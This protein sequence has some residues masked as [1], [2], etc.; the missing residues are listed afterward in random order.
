MNRVL[1]GVVVS[2]VVVVALAGAPAAGGAG[3]AL[4][5]LLKWGEPGTAAGLFDRPVFVAVDDVGNVFVTDSGNHRVQ[6]FNGDGEFLGGWGGLGPGD[7]QFNLPRGIAFFDGNEADPANYIY[8]VD[9]LNNRVQKFT[10]SGAF[11]TKWGSLGPGDGQFLVPSGV[12]VGPSGNVYVVDT[13]HHRV[14][15]FS[16]TGAFLGT[17]GG[18]GKAD[19]QFLNAHG[20]AVDE[21]E[22]VYVADSGYPSRVQVF[23]AG[24]AHLDTWTSFGTGTASAF[25][26]P[27]VAVGPSGDVFVTDG[28]NYQRVLRF[29]STGAPLAQWSVSV[30][31]DHGGPSP[32]GI[33]VAWTGDLYVADLEND[34]VKKY[35]R[36]SSSDTTPPVTTVSGDYRGWYNHPVT[37]RFTAKDEAGGS[38]VALTEARIQDRV[39]DGIW[40]AW[41]PGV[42]YVVPAPAD[43]TEDGDRVVQFRSVDQAGNVETARRARIRIDT[44]APRVTVDDAVART[45]KRALVTFHVK[46]AWSPKIKV[47]ARILRGGTVVHRATS[48][49]LKKQGTNGWGFTCDL[50]RGKYGLSIVAQDLAHNWSSPGTATLVVK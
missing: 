8:V 41:T 23:S 22:R 13:H 50:P 15:K 33:A 29:T 43:H 40:S 42:S 18:N 31:G 25:T 32:Y 47:I 11:V 2:L 38:G 1:R 39:L 14:Q 36:A 49:W 21:A 44:R 28:S 20:I 37:L 17:W 35:G 26:A 34:C 45:G 48:Q 10:A 30:K 7:G 46:D 3:G 5:F 12:A 16:P 27:G 24:G 9:S 19:G 6:K 4:D